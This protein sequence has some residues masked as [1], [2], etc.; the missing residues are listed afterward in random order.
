MKPTMS[1]AKHAA[2]EL[3]HQFGLACETRNP[4]AACALLAENITYQNVPLPAIHG[5]DAVAAFLT[6][7]MS[8]MSAFKWDVLAAVA[9]EDGKQ[10]LTERID[11]FVYENG[12]VTVSLMGIFEVADGFITAWRDYADIGTFVRDMGA[13]GRAPGPGIA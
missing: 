11:T 8:A 7:S 12:E 2:L 10:V 3:V 13:I 5:R 9:G 6:P 1:K 4:A